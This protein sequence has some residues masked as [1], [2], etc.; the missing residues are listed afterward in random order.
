MHVAAALHPRAAQNVDAAEKPLQPPVGAGVRRCRVTLMPWS[1]FP[2]TFDARAYSGNATNLCYASAAERPSSEPE[3]AL[4]QSLTTD[5]YTNVFAGAMPEQLEC[6]LPAAVAAMPA[7][8][9][10]ARRGAG[11]QQQAGRAR[12]GTPAYGRRFRQVLLTLDFRVAAGRQFDRAYVLQIGQ[13][14][15]S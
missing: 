9:A 10:G 3:F 2:C 4:A 13:A 8:G 1:A 6:T 11:R 14:V 7:G 5:G 12:A 15:V